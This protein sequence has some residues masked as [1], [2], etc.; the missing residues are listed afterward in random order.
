MIVKEE[1]GLYI[2]KIRKEQKL[3]L[4]DLHKKSGVSIPT[5]SKI[6]CGIKP[7]IIVLGKIAKA[8]DCDINKLFE[9]YGEEI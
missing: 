9:L 7:S 5:L 3:T 8:L 2:R 6:E 4:E 1:L